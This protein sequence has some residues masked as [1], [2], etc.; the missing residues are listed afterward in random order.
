MILASSVSTFSLVCNIVAAQNEKT[1]IIQMIG[2]ISLI[3]A[4][5]GDFFIFDV[6]MTILQ[7][8][9]VIVVLIFSISMII[10]NFVNDNK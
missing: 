1:A 4:F 10:F 5:L 6:E 3:Y 7:V 8:L 9:G 2:Y